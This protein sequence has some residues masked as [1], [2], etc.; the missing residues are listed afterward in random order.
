MGD[1]FVWGLNVILSYPIL[2]NRT[3]Q[4]KGILTI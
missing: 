2:C 3:K 1:S 4:E